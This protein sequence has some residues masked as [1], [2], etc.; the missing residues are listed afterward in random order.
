LEIGDRTGRAGVAEARRRTCELDEEKKDLI[1]L[2]AKLVNQIN[3]RAFRAELANGHS[4]VAYSRGVSP[5]E[6]GAGNTVKV[7]LSPFDMS[8]GRIVFEDVK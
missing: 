5:H 6:I 3:S 1:F 8:A 2:D 7:C 4:L